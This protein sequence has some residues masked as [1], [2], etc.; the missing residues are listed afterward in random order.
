MALVGALAIA[1]CGCFCCLGCGVK[2]KKK[3]DGGDDK[4]E[5]EGSYTFQ[6]RLAVQTVMGMCGLPCCCHEDDLWT[7]QKE[8]RG[9]D[10]GDNDEY[11]EDDEELQL[12][13]MTTMSTL[14]ECDD[15]DAA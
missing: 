1:T 11:Y 8:R 9:A 10:K 13:P 14:P 15:D 6:P 3:E 7:E 2:A 4:V 12:R 5:N